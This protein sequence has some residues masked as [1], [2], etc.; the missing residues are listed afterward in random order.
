V[1][2]GFVLVLLLEWSDPMIRSLRDV[3]DIVGESNFLEVGSYTAR[4]DN[5]IEPDLPINELSSLFRRLCN[6]MDASCSM[7]STLP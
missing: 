6:D 3:R 2:S 7:D 4:S 1:G 5:M